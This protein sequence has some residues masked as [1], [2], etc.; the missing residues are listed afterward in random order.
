MAT[1]GTIVVNKIVGCIMIER[2]YAKQWANIQRERTKKQKT[3]Q[4]SSVVKR[5]CLKKKEGKKKKKKAR[6]KTEN[7]PPL[8]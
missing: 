6:Q 8:E 5:E 2:S 1:M 7:L 3:Q 4:K